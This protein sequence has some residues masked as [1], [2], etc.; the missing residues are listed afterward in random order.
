MA[1]EFSQASTKEGIAQDGALQINN[2]DQQITQPNPHE[3]NAGQWPPSLLWKY[4]TNDSWRILKYASAGA[5]TREPD[6]W[7]RPEA[8]ERR[9]RRREQGDDEGDSFIGKLESATFFIWTRE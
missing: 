1:Q 3:N 9:Q 7:V 6:I 4:P 2:N 8:Y 5:M